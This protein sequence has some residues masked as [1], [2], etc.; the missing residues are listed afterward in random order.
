MPIVSSQR[1][2]LGSC[3]I[4]GL[5]LT[6]AMKGMLVTGMTKP[7]YY[8]DI[9]TLDELYASGLTIYT[10]SPSLI[11]TFGT[12]HINRTFRRFDINPT[13]GGLSRRVQTVVGT[14]DFWGVIATEKNVAAM[15][16]KSDY[17]YGVPLTKYQAS[18]GSPLLHVV[19]ECP[20]HYLLGY[21]MPR[22]SPYL[23]YINDGI[24]RLVEA[25][26][27]EHW[28]EITPSNA[29]TH[30]RFNFSYLR[31]IAAINK[32]N[33]KAFSLEDLQLAFYILAVGLSGSVTIFC[34]E[35][36]GKKKKDRRNT[37]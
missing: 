12:P 27:V 36:L 22:G 16:R 1:I 21:L 6:S 15:A 25:G 18:D 29:G 13:M 11:D 10:D 8:P 23:P 4:F 2:F 19:R 37:R 20:R 26:I 24:A 32:E 34:F 14:V 30:D 17:Q 33:S 7:Y 28:K 5:V 35:I 3:L 9:N 31:E